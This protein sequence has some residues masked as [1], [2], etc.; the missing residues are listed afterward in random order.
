MQIRR[1]AAALA[2]AA[3]L[4]LL[5]S[6]CGAG[7]TG[8]N[9]G[10]G[11]TDGSGAGGVGWLIDVTTDVPESVIMPEVIV[12]QGQTSVTVTAEGG[13]AGSGTLFMKGF[14]SGEMTVPISV[15]GR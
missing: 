11:S 7:N 10:T 13:K 5:V 1:G 6:A 9:T 3:A 4:G 15:A 12:P 2:G 14:G 8:N